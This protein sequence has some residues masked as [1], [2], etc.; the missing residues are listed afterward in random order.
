MSTVEERQQQIVK[1][2]S[3]IANWQDRYKRIITMGKELPPMPETLYQDQLLVKGCQ[4]KVWLQARRGDQGEVLLAGD[5]DAL[6]VKGLVSLVVQVY[7]GGTPKEILQDPQ[8]FIKSL[9]FEEALSPSRAN[10]FLAMMKQ[11]QLYAQ[12]FQMLET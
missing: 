6:I 1:E 11:I 10:G 7:S 2:F 3:G 5:S 9:G 4:S 8:G 12:A